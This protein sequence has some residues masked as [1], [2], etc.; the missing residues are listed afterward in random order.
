MTNG[1]GSNSSSFEIC[2][3]V[4][5]FGKG[6]RSKSQVVQFCSSSKN[7]NFT[8]PRQ[9]LQHSIRAHTSRAKTHG[10]CRRRRRCRFCRL[11]GLNTVG[12]SLFQLCVFN[13]VPQR[14]ATPLILL[15]KKLILCCSACHKASVI[16]VEFRKK[17]CQLCFILKTNNLE[18]Q[19]NKD[20]YSEAYLWNNQ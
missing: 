20:F 7:V 6:S 14:G 11:L 10:Y 9:K 4:S 17:L 8:R 2:Q 19:S 12:C 3:I 13:Q 15:T 18:D 1:R 5:F 16:R